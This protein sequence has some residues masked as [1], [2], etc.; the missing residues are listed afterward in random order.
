MFLVLECIFLDSNVI[1]TICE[2]F[3]I[4]FES[5]PMTELII[6]VE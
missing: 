4:F 3:F 2:N 5:I 6:G 1:E